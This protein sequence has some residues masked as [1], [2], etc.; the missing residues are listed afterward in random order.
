MDKLLLGEADSHKKELA[1][2][3]KINE[4]VDV[5]NK[6]ETLVTTLFKRSDDSNKAFF[7]LNEKV[8]KLEKHSHNIITLGYKMGTSTPIIIEEVKTS[9]P[10][11]QGDVEKIIADGVK[12]AQEHINKME[13]CDLQ[14]EKCEHS[15][16]TYNAQGTETTCL[17]CGE[18]FEANMKLKD[19]PIEKTCEN[20]D[21]KGCD[22]VGDT[23]C[24]NWQP[25]QPKTEDKLT[26]NPL[27][28]V[29]QTV[30]NITIGVLNNKVKEL[31]QVIQQVYDICNPYTD[32]IMNVS[33]ESKIAELLKPFINREG[34]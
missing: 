14:I 12:M 34:V 33:N 10:I 32:P 22:L 25:K 15:H 4:L 2:Y 26:N 3:N 31:Q 5:V 6:L 21:T 13:L 1:L 11:M 7:G 30:C 27:R 17:S 19:Q 9:E 16:Q 8:N 28:D 20:C 23:V 18:K 24:P 29:E